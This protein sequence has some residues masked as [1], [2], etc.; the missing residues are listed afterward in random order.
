MDPCRRAHMTQ[1]RVSFLV[2][3]NYSQ[4]MFKRSLPLALARGLLVLAV[5]VGIVLVA[6][7][8]MAGSGLY[9][10]ARL[11]YLEHR[12]RQLES[13]FARVTELRERIAR[14][15]EQ[16]RRF[17]TM[18]GVDRTPPPVDWSSAPYDSS[19]MPAW[20]LAEAW[21]N[22]PT[23]TVIPLEGYVVSRGYREAHK[24]MDLAAQAGSPVRAT[25]DGTVSVRDTDSVFGRYVLLDHAGGYSSY[26]GHLSDWRVQQG[27]T[28]RAGQTVGTV[29]S[30]GQSSAPHLHFEIRKDNRRVDPAEVLSF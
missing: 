15:E 5:V 1:K 13:E 25:A 10:M 16:E 29:G 3:T 9:R 6:A 26:Y 30:S 27:D 14:L 19:D 28:V 7:V 11:S 4:R 22:R 12:N 20:V 17:A 23:P 2:S 8:V 21:G 18:L 24:G